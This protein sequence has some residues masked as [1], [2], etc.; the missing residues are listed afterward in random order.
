MNW[1]SMLFSI[2]SLATKYA[3]GLR[4]EPQSNGISEGSHAVSLYRQRS[5]ECLVLANYLQPTIHTVEA[6]ILNVLCELIRAP[7]NPFSIYITFSIAVRV[8]MRMGY[9]RDPSRFPQISI[10]DGEIRRRVWNVV[11]QL[12]VLLAFQLGQPTLINYEECDTQI[13]LNVLNVDL[14]PGIT[15][16]PLPRV[17]N[18]PDQLAYVLARAN[19]TE[20]LGRIHRVVSSI[21]PTSYEAVK[22]L[23]KILNSKF[24]EVPHCLKLHRGRNIDPDYN[25]PSVMMRRVCI[26]LLY[27]QARCVL[28]RRFMTAENQLHHL[29]WDTCVDASL[30]IIE[31]QSFVWGESR[32][33]GSFYGHDWKVIKLCTSHFLLAAMILCLALRALGRDIPTASN[34]EDRKSERLYLALEES[35]RIWKLWGSTTEEASRAMRLLE[36]LLDKAGKQETTNQFRSWEDSTVTIP[37]MAPTASKLISPNLHNC[38]HNCALQST[39]MPTFPLATS[40][41]PSSNTPFEYGGVETSNHVHG[42]MENIMMSNE[43]IDWVSTSRLVILYNGLTD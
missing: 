27:Q 31:H 9:H 4:E 41:D 11:V 17:H 38:L 35:Y 26:D 20:V 3:A 34:S 2:M 7:R 21:H 28:H 36:F 13:P 25:V 15:S 33:G 40:A 10:F 32:S 23:Q 24:N 12:D 43:N 22:Q 8:S 42:W 37:P 29:S 16:L 1:L 19:L 30:R 39:I 14:H 5:A 18:P 6:L